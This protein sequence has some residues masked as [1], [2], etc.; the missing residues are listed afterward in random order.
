MSRITLSGPE[1]VATLGDEDELD[2]A[3]A[4]LLLD[5]VTGKARGILRDWPVLDD[6]APGISAAAA[7][8]LAPE[9][10]LDVVISRGVPS[11]EDWERP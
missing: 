4:A 5:L 9:P 11:T 8:R 2:A 7:R 10:G 6:S 3:P 1:G